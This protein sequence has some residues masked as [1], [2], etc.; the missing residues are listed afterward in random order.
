MLG[1][2]PDDRFAK[3]VLYS[4]PYYYAD[5]QL[6]ARAD[7]PLPL[8]TTPLAV[9]RGVAVRGIRG[10]KVRKFSSLEAILKAVAQGREQAGY[11]ISTR[12]HWLAEQRWPG[13]L[14]FFDGGSELS[15]RFPLCVALRKTEGDLKAAI[16][17][18]LAELA[19]SGKLATTFARWHIP[20]SAPN[21]GVEPS[22]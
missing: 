5:Y 16:D 21:K 14:T 15:D 20:Y 8:D 18:A 9:E 1:V 13:K 17:K 2:M 6:V 12:G 19:Q 4:K 22:K 10:R 7:A 3:R 11:V